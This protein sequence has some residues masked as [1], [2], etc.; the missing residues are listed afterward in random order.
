MAEKIDF[1]KGDEVLIKEFGHVDARCI[2]NS[3]IR[4]LGGLKV[5]II[6]E[7]YKRKGCHG[8]AFDAELLQ[9]YHWGGAG[10]GK[11]YQFVNADAMIEKID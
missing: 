8:F 7:I 11:D 4:Q 9:E 2:L 3:E 6:S 10:F 1:K 5:K